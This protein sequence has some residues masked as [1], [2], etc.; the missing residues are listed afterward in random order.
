MT[1]FH[2]RSSRRRVAGMLAAPLALA[3]GVA[4]SSSVAATTEPPEDTEAAAEIT[5]PPEDTEAAAETTEAAAEVTAAPGGLLAELQEA[6]SITIGIANE[7]PYG[8]EDEEGEPSGEA[9]EVAKAVLAELGITEVDAVVVE[10]GSLIPGL[11]AGQYDMIAAG[12]FINPE[13]AEQIIFSDPDY[14]ISQSFA[15]AEGNPMEISDFASVAE[16][17]ATLAVVPGT[18]EEDFALES[19]VSEDQLVPFGEIEAQYEALVA[20]DVDAV[21][22]TRATVE[23][24]AEQMEGFE[25]TEP[26]IYV[27]PDGNEVLGCGGFGFVDQ[28][29]RDAFN[30]V[31]HQLQ[32]DGTVAEIIAEFGFTQD[33]ADLALETTV[34]SILAAAAPPETTVVEGTAPDDTEAV[35]EDTEEMTEDTEEV[36]EDTEA[37]E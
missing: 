7:P 16:S 9:P 20:G 26:F 19:G 17:G 36:T 33:E 22:G 25:A 18:V 15:V 14:C 8:F 27:D 37:D 3:L 2:H 35:T 11:Q 29:F 10:F 30:D 24:R 13:R 21:P 34:E 31:L 12:M 5:E 28:E 1:Q 6:G 4:A 23:L 32:E